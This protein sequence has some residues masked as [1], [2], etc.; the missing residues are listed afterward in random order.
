M[1][2]KTKDDLQKEVEKL[3]KELVSNKNKYKALEAEAVASGKVATPIMGHFS[4]GKKHFSFKPG[5]V[6]VRTLT[7]E[8]IP[9]EELMKIANDP[10]H[11]VDKT[12]ISSYPKLQ[13]FD[14]AAAKQYLELLVSM[15]YGLLQEGVGE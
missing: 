14:Q 7:G 6:F 11:K 8:V 3:K 5:T 1:A 12:V 13:A 10:D 9:T 2:D 15:G 4:V